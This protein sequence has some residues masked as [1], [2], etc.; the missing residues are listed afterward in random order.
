VLALHNTMSVSPVSCAHPEC[1]DS[2]GHSDGLAPRADAQKGGRDRD[3]NTPDEDCNSPDEE[4]SPEQRRTVRLSRASAGIA[5]QRI[6]DTYEW[7]N[8]DE[9]S[10]R[11]LSVAQQFNEAFDNEELETGEMEDAS[12]SESS[13]ED[14]DSQSGDDGS[15][16]SSFV[17]DG[18][19]TEFSDSEEEWTPVKRSRQEAD[20]EL[21]AVSSSEPD[22]EVLRAPASLSEASPEATPEADEAVREN[23]SAEVPEVVC[24]AVPEQFGFLHM[25][26]L[27]SPIG[28]YNLWVL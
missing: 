18:S 10:G 12:A 9:E 1:A 25:E 15:Y 7:E 14:E 3:G 19:G 5:R 28:F 17:T 2:D 27:N 4:A 13:C 6:I 24:E 11:F 20:A 26:E 16:E 8:C 21:D 22:A 23:V